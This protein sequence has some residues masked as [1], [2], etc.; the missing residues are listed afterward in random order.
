MKQKFVLLLA[1]LMC[2]MQGM[3]AEGI[4]VK[5]QKTDQGVDLKKAAIVVDQ[6]DFKVV[7]NCAGLLAGD[8]H[9][10]LGVKPEV[11]NSADN[12][13]Y[14]VIAGSVT[15][16][17]TI[18]RLIKSKKIDVSAIRNGWERYAI[19]T[20]DHPM[21]GIDRAL[22]I[23]GSD[24]R[25]T[26]YGI[27]SLSEALGVTPYVWWADVKPEKMSGAFVSGNCISKE[28]S[29]K[30]R[31][32]FIN[33]EDWGMHPWAKKTFE[34]ETGDIG[35]KTYKAVAELILRLKGNMLAPAMHS[36]SM[37][38]YQNEEN[39]RAVDEY[40]IVI[41]TSHCEPMLLNNA[42]KLEWDTKTDGDWNYKTNKSRIYEK[43][44]QRIKEAKGFENIYTTAMRGLHDAGMRGDL[45]M[46]EK[47]SL[48][49]EVIRDQRTILSTNLKRKAEEI[50]QIF[51]PYK[52]ALDV[53]ENGLQVPQDITLVWPDDNYGYMKR[54]SNKEE[55]LRSGGAGVYYHTSY[56]GGPHDYLWLQTT[57]P[58]LM[59]EEL[60][61]AY[62]T[63]AKDYWLLN[64]G[65][66]KPAELAMKTFFDMAFDMGKF[67]Y[68][69]VNLHQAEFLASIFGAQY[70][71]SFQSILD[72]YYRLAW[73]RKPEFMGWER[74]W[75]ERKYQNIGTTDFS[76]TAYNDLQQRLYDYESISAKTKTIASGLKESQKAA[77]FELL[78]Y[79]VLASSEMNKKFL[80]AQLNQEMTTSLKG[81][82][83]NW[84]AE[85]SQE[86]YD[87]I[88]SLTHRYNEMLGGKWRHMMALAPGWC[89]KYQKMPPV[90]KQESE[91]EK[92][93]DVLPK[94]EKEIYEGFQVPPLAAFGIENKDNNY[95][96]RLINGIGYD[97]NALQ[98]G[99]ATEEETSANSPD[100]PRFTLHFEQEGCDSVEVMVYTLPF[101]PLYK[102][103]STAFGISVDNQEPQI[104][105]NS[106]K[107]YSKPW[108]DQVL[109]NGALHRARFA[110]GKGKRHTLSLIRQDGGVMIERV[111]LNFGG[112]KPTYVGPRAK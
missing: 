34:K 61:K 62:D 19:S 2:L 57:P 79:P 38:F 13:R 108:K 87:S 110:L 46:S 40:A 11:R 23:A 111:I 31:G 101:F 75:D 68:D 81:G 22:V 82:E 91:E 29:V 49:Q 98:M 55:Q 14:A 20:I 27:L 44:D 41:T 28:P 25:G 37:P 5:S 102:G 86:A 59:Y 12:V 47:V 30:Y 36:C 7:G 4:S 6:C 21:K 16:S 58:V 18:Q 56:L 63:N 67:D 99:E 48:L 52:E 45:T 80:F 64:V 71:D 112:L 66:I 78:E 42:S 100:A 10:V 95:A 107:E 84:A 92:P 105:Q 103:K 1:G 94:A 96:L 3:K 89:A 15:K 104:R 53:Y 35:P 65:D 9:E 85:K 26:A 76:S 60:K 17:K 43:F 39:K 50:P 97:W 73:S 33:D 74:E 54:L 32:I 93:F 109:Q 83:A 24:A 70:K 8:I 69:N 72:N 106:T 88:Q 90:I 77:F 51:V